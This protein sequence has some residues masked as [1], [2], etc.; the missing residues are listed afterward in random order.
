MYPVYKAITNMFALKSLLKVPQMPDYALAVGEDEYH[1]TIPLKI[2]TNPKL[3]AQRPVVVD[4]NKVA[5][6]KA[7]IKGT[8][9]TITDDMFESNDFDIG[10]PFEAN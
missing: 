3:P 10:S 1:A 6:E 7:A 4:P 9:Q 2:F 8:G 5:Y